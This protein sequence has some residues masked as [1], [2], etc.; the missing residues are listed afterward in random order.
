MACGMR[1]AASADMDARLLALRAVVAEA[2]ASK[3]PRRTVACLG[4]AVAAA[5]FGAAP[6][7]APAARTVAPGLEEATLPQ[8]SEAQRRRR[9]RGKKNRKDAVLTAHTN[10]NEMMTEPLVDNVADTV[11]TIDTDSVHT[12][13]FEELNPALADYSTYLQEDAEILLGIGMEVSQET[14]PID[15]LLWHL[16]PLYGQR[17]ATEEAGGYEFGTIAA[18]D[19]Y[20]ALPHELQYVLMYDDGDL[21]HLDTAEATAAVELARVMLTTSPSKTLR[22]TNADAHLRDNQ[23]KLTNEQAALVEAA[24]GA[25]LLH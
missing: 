3:A 4:A 20:I 22:R 16:L 7:N 14:Q 13:T 8:P 12:E 19:Q 10:G 11:H 5:L 25:I 23:G 1:Y 2:V 17:A 6:P 21:R 18:V 9:R 24:S 15:E